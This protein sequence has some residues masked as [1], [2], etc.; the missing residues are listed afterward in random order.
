MTMT[1]ADQAL[2]D[3]N[4]FLDATNESRPH[5]QAARSLI[6]QRENIVISA[7]IVREYLVVA[8]RPVAVNGFGMDLPS[9][10]QNMAE[11][12][13]IAR[14]LP[15]EKPILP[16][17]LKLIRQVPVQGK[18]LHDAFLVATMLVQGVGILITSNAEDFT[19]FGQMITIVGP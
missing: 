17:F 3:T 10:M 19:R 4:V 18:T 5:H 1:G 12:R 9:A 11:F 2:V 6:E 16:Q 14:L 8:T 7:Q 15:E 13:R